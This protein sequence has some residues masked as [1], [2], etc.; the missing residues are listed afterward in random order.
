MG[1]ELNTQQIYA[2]YDLET[3]WGKQNDQLFEI[4]GAAGTGKTTLIRYFI[5]RIGLDLSDVAF[6]VYSVAYSSAIFTNFSPSGK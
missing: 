4:S 3:W 1:I 5:D 2:L 6:V